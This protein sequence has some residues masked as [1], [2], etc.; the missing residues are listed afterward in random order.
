MNPRLRRAKTPTGL[1]SA[2]RA[3]KTEATIHRSLRMAS[4]E[5]N[6]SAIK[7]GSAPPRNDLWS[8]SKFRMAKNP[9]TH[10]PQSR[11]SSRTL[12]NDEP[13]QMTSKALRSLRPV[14][15]EAAAMA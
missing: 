12:T 5:A 7:R 10:S 9:A 3:P 1:T 2:A 6:S 15:R 11:Q 14:S 8:Q 4:S 13:Q